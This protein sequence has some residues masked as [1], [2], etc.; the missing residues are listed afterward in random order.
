MLMLSYTQ[1]DAD[2]RTSYELFENEAERRIELHRWR[3]YPYVID[4]YDGL[5]VEVAAFLVNVHRIGSVADAEAYIARLRGIQPLFRQVEERLAASEAAGIVPPKFVFPQVAADIRALLKGRPFERSGADS[6]LLKDFKDKVGALDLPAERRA[7]LVDSATTALVE[8]VKPAYESLARKLAQ[9]EKKATPGVAASQLPS[10]DGYYRAMLRFYTTSDLSPGE[11]HEVALAEVARLHAE[12][13]KLGEG[14]GTNEPL[15]RLFKAMSSR[16]GASYPDT[17]AGRVAYLDDATRH[18]DAMKGKLGSLFNRVP[19][20]PLQLQRVASLQS[21]SAGNAFYVDAADGSQPATVFF[22]VARMADMPGYA[23]EALVYHEG[24][25]GH[26]LERSHT[27]AI[28]GL[29]D[30]R[31]FFPAAAYTEGWALYAERVAKEAG[32]YATPEAEYGRLVSELRSAAELV[33]D[34]GIHGRK[35]TRE[36]AIKYFL[37]NTPLGRAAATEAAERISVTPGQAAAP[38][39]GLL[40]IAELRQRALTELGERFDVREFHDAVLGSGPVPLN[41]LTREVTSYIERKRPPTK[42]AG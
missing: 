21:R 11:M 32:G 17:E 42:P 22:D 28:P 12:I 3:L 29:A 31:R 40:R 41:A 35:W 9:L 2:H 5:H 16:P 10:G 38:T 7:A 15:P 24:L 6:V 33:V 20:E 30:F 34:T 37:D 26:H 27:L 25:P 1:L 4:Q 14:L 8:A 23:L 13:L 18:L 36:E 19:D 39:I